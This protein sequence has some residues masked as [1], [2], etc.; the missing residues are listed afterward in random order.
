MH[1]DPTHHDID[2]EALS[3]SRRGFMQTAVAAAAVTQVPLAQAAAPKPAPFNPPPVA[4]QPFQLNINGQLYN[5]T[6]EPRVT[7]LDALRESIGLTGSKKG[8]D[9]GQCGACT[10]LINGRRFNS[11]LTLAVMHEGDKI[12]TIEGIANGEQLAP[13]QAA[14]IDKDAFQCGYCTPGQICSAVA[15]LDEMRA[16]TASAASADVR[17]RQQTFGDDEVRE[18][19][20]GNLCRCGA[21]PNIVNAIQFVANRKA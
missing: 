1:E 14:F 3:L 16:G 2:E 13:I 4:P 8:C 12:T 7:L 20:S 17:K 6:L 11:C 9:R 21:Y 5:L 15:C 10:V 19:M 18:R